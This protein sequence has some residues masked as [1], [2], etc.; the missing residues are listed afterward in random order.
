MSEGR[1]YYAFELEP[2]YNPSDPA[3]SKVTKNGATPG[4]YHHNMYD[5]S[6]EHELKE[7]GDCTSTVTNTLRTTQVTAV[8]E[9]KPAGKEPYP[10]VTL[11]LQY[12]AGTDENDNEIWEN[13]GAPVTL[14]RTEGEGNEWEY[15]W[16]NIPLYHPDDPSIE[17]GE[18]TYRVVE[19]DGDGYVQVGDTE[20]GTAPDDTTPLYT[21]P[22][23]RWWTL[24]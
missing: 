16:E 7:N 1:Q 15:T 2:G 4:N 10:Q 11:Q 22:T 13:M 14:P 20:V 18:T 23:S 19:L 12:Q 8:K 17:T 5:A 9:W 24:R 21:S 3:G 6:D